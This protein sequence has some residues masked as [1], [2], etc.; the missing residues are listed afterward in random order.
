MNNLKN[1]SGSYALITGGSSG[2]G[3]AFACYLAERNIHCIIVS[4]ERNE[5]AHTGQEI[6]AKYPAVNI[7]AYECN[8]AN[9]DEI[10]QI[11][12]STEN[13][14]IRIVINCAGIGLSGYFVQADP[15]L[16][17]ELIDVDIKAVVNITHFFCK[18]FQHYE[19]N[20]IIMNIS[21]VNSEF[22]APIPFS[23]VYSAGKSFIKY[24]T[25]A[26]QFEMKKTKIQIM[27]VSCGP[28]ITNFQRRTNTNYVN[29]AEV[30]SNVPYKAFQQIG[31][32]SSV[33]T[34]SISKFYVYLLKY[35][36][37]PRS[38]KISKLAQFYGKKLGRVENSR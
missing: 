15:G 33:I 12:Q 17:T 1:Y 28:T 3:K 22:H 11:I 13:L 27:N 4:N 18:K 9:P 34:N 38:Y 36:P 5:L 20:T 32:R 30:A 29:F 10:H 21:S 26:I 6:K 19:H 7:M 35:L 37:Y 14:D 23:A 24:F 31:K 25:E 16:L 8:L 2:I